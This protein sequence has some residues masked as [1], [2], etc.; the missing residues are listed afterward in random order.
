VGNNN[1]RWSVAQALTD[2]RKRLATRFSR[3]TA[4]ALLATCPVLAIGAYDVRVVG[5]VFDRG[6]DQMEVAD[7]IE[8]NES[9]MYRLRPKEGQAFRVR[10]SADND[11]T[12]FIVYAPGKWPGK[13]LHDSDA[14]GV[15]EYEGV[16]TKTGPHAVSVFQS[17]QAVEQQSTSN[18]KLIIEVKDTTK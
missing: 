11:H 5:V 16:V 17:P 6:A 14:S 4:I 3:G 9:V 10:L 18:Y 13:V 8:G 1:A 15:M 12:D 7:T 2:L